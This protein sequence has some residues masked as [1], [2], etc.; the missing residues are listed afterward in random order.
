MKEENSRYLIPAVA[1]R[2]MTILPDIIIHFDLSRKKSILAVEQAMADDQKILVITQ[3]D[4]S[5]EDPEYKD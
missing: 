3:K 2:G 1:L 5:T 4:P